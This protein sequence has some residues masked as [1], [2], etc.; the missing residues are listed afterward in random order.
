MTEFKEVIDDGNHQEHKTGAVRSSPSGKGRYDLFLALTHMIFRVSRHFENGEV[1]YGPDNWLKGLPL[2]RYIDSAFRH[3]CQYVAGDEKEDHLAAAIWNLMCHGETRNEIEV[4]RLPESLNDMPFREQQPAGV[5]IKEQEQKH[6]EQVPT[7]PLIPAGTL[8]GFAGS[9]TVA[10]MTVKKTWHVLEQLKHPPAKDCETYPTLYIAGPM[11]GKP[12]LNWAAFDD[13]AE[14]L[15]KAGFNVINP[16]HEDRLRGINSEDYEKGQTVPTRLL[17]EIVHD[18]LEIIQALRPEYGDGLALLS[19]WKNST[20]ATA[21][22]GVADWLGLRILLV[23]TWI[24][25]KGN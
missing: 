22:R 17:H 21:E 11:R 3:L 1:V 25:I 12:G 18:D 16:A 2:R 5:W 19:G 13:A 15:R 14:R 24:K 9:G 8:M 7:E 4:G 10:L 23:D 6:V 20:G